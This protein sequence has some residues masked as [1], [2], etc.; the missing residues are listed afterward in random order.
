MKTQKVRYRS[1]REYLAES[2]VSRRW[3][4][5][6]S[7]RAAVGDLLGG[8]CL[9]VQREEVRGKSV[10]L[11]TQ[12]QLTAALAL[13]E[14]DGLASRIVVCPPDLPSHHL[15]SV[16]ACADVDAIVSDVK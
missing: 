5:G 6:S 12:G 13:I 2:D 1:I 14:L 10:L 15:E 16:I 8:S 3:I 11:K 9:T 4:W 7:A